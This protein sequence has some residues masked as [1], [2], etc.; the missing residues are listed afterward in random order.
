MQQYLYYL[1]L[2]FLQE[3]RKLTS[4]HCFLIQFPI[5]QSSS[6]H[7]SSCISWILAIFT[8]QSHPAHQKKI[9]FL[10]ENDSYQKKAI[11]IQLNRMKM[12]S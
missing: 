5:T 3:K 11:N 10:L 8:Y 2:P 12:Q 7:P 6:L 4:H 1:H 9:I